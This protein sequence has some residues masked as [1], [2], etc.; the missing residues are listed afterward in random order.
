MS[1]LNRLKL[2][3]FCGSVSTPT[4]G[5]TPTPGAAIPIS[6]GPTWVQQNTGAIAVGDAGHTP[7][8]Y[9]QDTG[10]SDLAAIQ[11]NL[12][13][14]HGSL[15]IYRQTMIG[16]DVGQ[17]TWEIE[18]NDQTILLRGGIPNLGAAGRW[19]WVRIYF[20]SNTPI[21]V[22][23]DQIQWVST[24][25]DRG[26]FG[27]LLNP[28]F[29][30]SG[31][32]RMRVIAA[33]HEGIERSLDITVWANIPGTPGYIDRDARAVWVDATAANGDTTGAGTQAN[34]Y[35]T[36]EFAIP[37]MVGTSSGASTKEGG[38]VYLMSANDNLLD[39]TN[40]GQNGN[41]GTILPA[42]VRP[43]PALGTAKPKITRTVP[44]VGAVSGELSA[45]RFQASF[46]GTTMTVTSVDYG[47]IHVGMRIRGGSIPGTT[48]TV[49]AMGTGSGGAGTYTVTWNSGVGPTA[50]DPVHGVST[51]NLQHRR[52]T[53]K[54]CEF[55][56]SRIV[57]F[58]DSGVFNLY[59]V[60]CAFDSADHGG[61]A[62][63][64]YPTNKLYPISQGSFGQVW[65][66]DLGAIGREFGMFGCSGK[67]RALGNVNKIVDCT[68]EFLWDSFI[69]SKTTGPQ[70]VFVFNYKATQTS[71]FK[72][73]VHANSYVTVSGPPTTRTDVDGSWVI[74]PVTQDSW[75]QA[76]SA[77]A[78]VQVLT[79]TLTGVEY[80][81]DKGKTFV[82]SGRLSSVEL[83]RESA[84]R[85][86]TALAIGDRLQIFSVGHGDSLQIA[87][88]ATRRN[89]VFQNYEAISAYGMQL[90]LWQQTSKLASGL[91][92]Q[93]LGNNVVFDV[94]RTCR[95]GD[96]FRIGTTNERAFIV[97]GEAADGA[98]SD[99]WRLSRTLTPGTFSGAALTA[100]IDGGWFENLALRRLPNATNGQWNT[101]QGTFPNSWSGRIERMGHYNG[102]YLCS[103]FRGRREGS[104]VSQAAS[105]HLMIEQDQCNAQEIGIYGCIA[106]DIGNLGSG[107]LR[108]DDFVGEG[109]HLMVQGANAVPSGISGVT[110]ADFTMT[111]DLRA[112]MS[113]GVGLCS[114][115]H[116]ALVPFDLRGNARRVGDPFGAVAR[117]AA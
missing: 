14:P 5:P 80:Y 49:T 93:I 114:S 115:T 78:G 50:I 47:T 75:G 15:G 81:D 6:P 24:G 61:Q 105:F 19:K 34:P 53:F 103:T 87:N 33:S 26:K 42:Q 102:G 66:G 1:S 38:Y 116:A 40:V 117:F 36:I 23:G 95:H 3:L 88:P 72:T 71:Y 90:M 73:R 106:D 82:T 85:D 39:G 56:S 59:L 64:V 55:E 18:S 2:S 94:P 97:A 110:Q 100:S 74:I 51:I 20:E 68:F 30:K 108:S 52:V 27:I 60:N 113:A 9:G 11:P 101:P 43:A 62:H 104:P 45:A 48:H 98:S 107:T 84:P 112:P 67:I 4:P 76:I 25:P 44:Q 86:L 54:D 58:V 99:T 28:R 83:R 12:V 37:K 111:D 57:S 29:T 70:S 46:S 7:A 22:S 16:C 13:T 79:G 91:T 65:V 89:W 31:L 10:F 17:N 35:R 21:E 96:S 69:H 63:P 77:D 41:N 109:V 8:Y 92:G 32:A